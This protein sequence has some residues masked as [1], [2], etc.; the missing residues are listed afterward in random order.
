MMRDI[1][2]GFLVLRLI[3]LLV[4]VIVVGLLLGISALTRGSDIVGAAILA[5]VVV[6]AAAMGS[7]V[8][9]RASRRPR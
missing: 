2:K 1:F 5:T 9:R 8:A 7:L 6:V 3:A 4:L